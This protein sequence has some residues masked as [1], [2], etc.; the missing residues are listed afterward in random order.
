MRDGDLL[1]AIWSV[2]VPDRTAFVGDGSL[3]VCSVS[4]ERAELREAV[5]TVLA[6]VAGGARSWECAVVVPRGEDVESASAALRDA[7]LPVACRV[8]ERSAGVRVLGRLADCLAPSAGEPFARRRG[9]RPAR[10]RPAARSHG[11]WRGRAVARRGPAGRGGGR[12]GAVDGAI[13]RQA[14]G[15]RA[16][17]RDDQGPAA[18]RSWTTRTS[19]RA[20]LKPCRLRLAAARGL[21]RVAGALTDVCAGVPQRASWDDWADFFARVAAAVFD[22]R[23]AD[24]AR[25]AASRLRALAVL[26]EESR[27]RRGGRRA[28]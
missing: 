12:A 8:A 26:H 23:T 7:G 5:R 24:E 14:Q 22:S 10:R 25:D 19:S 17:A 21:S 9:R 27:G 6:A 20:R 2:D 18:T 28:P 15:A 3:A 4:D 1:R 11:A 13:G 16:Q